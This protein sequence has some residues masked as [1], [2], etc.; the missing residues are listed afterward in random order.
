MDLPWLLSCPQLASLDADVKA[1]LR[2]AL[3]ATADAAEAAELLGPFLAEA[4]PPATDAEMPGE[5]G[6]GPW[7]FANASRHARPATLFSLAVGPG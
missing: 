3:E 2:E 1:Y 6:E 7:R 5:L 4:E